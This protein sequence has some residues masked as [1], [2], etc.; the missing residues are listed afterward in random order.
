[1]P[2]LINISVAT[3]LWPF[4]SSWFCLLFSL[5]SALCCW[6]CVGS[7]L[8]AGCTDMRLL[9][10]FASLRGDGGVLIGLCT[11]ESARHRKIIIMTKTLGKSIYSHFFFT[12]TH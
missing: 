10:V 12:L 4:L 7:V 3:G 2:L 8:T 9:I 6:L 5:S 1:M 11:V